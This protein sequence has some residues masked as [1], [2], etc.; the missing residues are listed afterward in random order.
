MGSPPESRWASTWIKAHLHYIQD[1]GPS[2]HVPSSDPSELM[3]RIY[4]DPSLCLRFMSRMSMSE[5]VATCSNFRGHRRP[6]LCNVHA[7]S[8]LFTWSILQTTKMAMSSADL[9]TIIATLRWASCGPGTGL[10]AHP[11]KS[12][13]RFGKKC[14]LTNYTKATKNIRAKLHLPLLDT[15]HCKQNQQ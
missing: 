15:L 13:Y 3:F 12:Q 1:L 4:T 6:R 5:L 8:R 14:L 11:L 2:I 9:V 10:Q 7:Q